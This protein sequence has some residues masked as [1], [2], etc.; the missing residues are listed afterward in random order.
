MRLSIRQHPGRPIG[1]VCAAKAGVRPQRPD[2]S[3]GRVFDRQIR[4]IRGGT[5]PTAPVHD[6]Q[7][8]ART[9]FVL[10]S[11]A[12]GGSHLGNFGLYGGGDRLRI[13]RGAPPIE[14]GTRRHSLDWMDHRRAGG[15]HRR[16]LGFRASRSV[17][18]RSTRGVQ[19]EDRNRGGS[20]APESVGR[21]DHRLP[22]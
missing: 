4:L 21:T 5:R 7:C 10:P 14:C 1:Q 17:V 19:W 3:V 8:V 15:R 22:N 9:P 2:W 13:C 12:T 18:T 16:H 20:H 6:G 11:S